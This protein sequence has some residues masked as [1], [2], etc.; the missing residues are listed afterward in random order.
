MT[1]APSRTIITP[2]GKVHQIGKVQAGYRLNY[3]PSELLKD[4]CP[5]CNNILQVKQIS[6]DSYASITEN[7]VPQTQYS[8]NVVYDFGGIEPI[9]NF[10]VTVQINPALANYFK[11]VDISQIVTEEID[12]SLLAIQ[13]E[14]ETLTLP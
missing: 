1:F 8:I 9:P 14:T 4:G 5:L 13:D 3:I 2:R 6:G 11:G 10:N 7:Y 12:P